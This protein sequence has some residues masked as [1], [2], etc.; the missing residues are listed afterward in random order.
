MRICYL[1]KIGWTHKR[2]F[3]D[4]FSKLYEVHNF[5]IHNRNTSVLN[6][7][8]DF[9]GKVQSYSLLRNK[10]LNPYA[11][12]LLKSLDFQPLSH[13]VRMYKGKQPTISMK[14]IYGLAC[15]ELG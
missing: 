6:N 7:I 15:L 10:S 5:D 8:D 2:H 13:T 12:Q 9:E 1:G 11:N 4:Y 14:E 3:L